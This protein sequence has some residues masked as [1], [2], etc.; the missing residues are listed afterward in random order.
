MVSF[1]LSKASTRNSF[2]KIIFLKERAGIFFMSR[3]LNSFVS[4]T[5]LPAQAKRAIAFL[6]QSPFLSSHS[7]CSLFFTGSAID[8]LRVL[9]WLFSP[10]YSFKKCFMRTGAFRDRR[11]SA[12]GISHWH[13]SR[14]HF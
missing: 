4:S 1:F 11:L 9:Q 5:A 14:F 2:P 13:F 3:F 6:F 8:F 10:A 12:T 7:A